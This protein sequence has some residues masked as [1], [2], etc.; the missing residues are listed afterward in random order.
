MFVHIR[1]GLLISIM[2][3][4]GPFVSGLCISNNRLK[5]NDI[6]IEASLIREDGHIKTI[7]STFVIFLFVILLHFVLC[8]YL[9]TIDFATYITYIEK[10]HFCVPK[11]VGENLSVPPISCFICVCDSKIIINN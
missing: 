11:Y 1:I 10:Y 5:F 4:I 7:I 6:L 9:W 8:T 2:F 3:D